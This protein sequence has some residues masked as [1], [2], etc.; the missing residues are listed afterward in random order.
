MSFD[1]GYGGGDTTGGGDPL[2][3]DS[4]SFANDPLF[5]TDPNLAATIDPTMGSSVDSSTLF[6]PG[7]TDPFSAQTTADNAT[8]AAEVAPTDPYSGFG[9]G[10]TGPTSD[11]NVV[12]QDMAP[13]GAGDAGTVSGDVISS[14]PGDPSAGGG[15]WSALGSGA[16][17]LLTGLFKGSGSSP[18]ARSMVSAGGRVPINYGGMRPQIPYN[19]P[20]Q[21]ASVLPVSRG[22]QPVSFA[23]DFLPAASTTLADT[24]SGGFLS[25]LGSLAGKYLPT[26][27]AGA[28]GAA[29]GAAGEALLTPSGGRIVGG[30]RGPVAVSVPSKG[31]GTHVVYYVPRGRALLYSGDFAAVKRVHKVGAM[32][33]R[34][35]K[36][37]SY[38]SRRRSRR[39]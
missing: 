20:P 18:L 15:F 39:R 12:S 24:S 17:S 34:Y 11:S 10:D 7:L 23:S 36:H 27:L 26:I 19:T 30:A 5:S 9:M 31:G 35:V 29:A 21:M 28:G 8:A 22:G 32:C 25:T 3:S 13:I 38:G 37:R 2:Y 33:A 4:S 16:A 1:L 14:N 6:D